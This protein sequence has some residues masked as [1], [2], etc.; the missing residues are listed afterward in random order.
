MSAENVELV[1]LLQ[2]AEADL[3]EIFVKGSAELPELY[4]PDLERLGNDFV[5][6]FISA[7]PGVTRPTYR[8]FEGFAEG[9]RD[10]LEPWESYW[11]TTEEYIEA[12]DKVVALIRVTA[13]TARD[14]VAV[15]HAPAAVYT[16]ED[17]KLVRVRLYLDRDTALAEALDS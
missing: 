1:K 15:E 3:V 2:P 17:G 6:E 13:R 14:G 11:M 12:G 10:W 16:I 5:V 4:A 7:T 9:W 8:G